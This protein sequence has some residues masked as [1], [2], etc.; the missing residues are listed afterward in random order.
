[1]AVKYAK[2]QLARNNLFD[3]KVGET[4][5]YRSGRGGQLVTGKVVKMGSKYVQVKTGTT[6]WRVPANMLEAA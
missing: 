1:M 2:N 4:V 6:I 3:C 5:K